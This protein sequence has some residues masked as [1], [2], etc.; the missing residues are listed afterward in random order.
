MEDA[1]PVI[2]EKTD[3][4]ARVFGRQYPHFVESYRLEDADIAI[5]ISGGHAVTCRAAVNRMRAQGI[6]IGMARLLWV[7]PFPG[8][9]LREA[10]AGVKAVGVVETNLGL[11]GASYGGI[12]S[13]DVTTALYHLDGPRPLVTSFMAG[14]G[15]E[16]VPMAEF[17]WMAGKLGQAIERG[18]VEKAAHW[19][20]FE[21]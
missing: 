4:F 17:D 9:D 20:G 2:R 16:T 15:G 12:L 8:D 5:V 3:E 6:K 7:R 21:D 14:L 18:R 13:L 11:G 19:V 1:I 10:L